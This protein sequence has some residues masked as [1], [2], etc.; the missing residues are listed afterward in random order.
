MT[1]EAW[2]AV[3][4]TTIKHCWDHTSIQHDLIMIH[5][6]ARQ[7]SHGSESQVSQASLEAWN[8]L[9]DLTTSQKTLPEAED[10]LEKLYD[11][12]YQDSDWWAVLTAIT[13]SETTGDAIG[14][15]KAVGNIIK[16][17]DRQTERIETEL[18]EAVTEL[19]ACHQIF[20]PI[21]SLEDL[22]DIL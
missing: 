1:K 2:D 11:S 7:R 9:E 18:I 17:R 16:E 13:G 8:I 22:G 15:F 4:P 5:I 6:P 14:K 19:K 10:S 3:K 20:G 21:P 12:T